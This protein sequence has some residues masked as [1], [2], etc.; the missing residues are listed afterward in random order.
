M[1][2]C[3]DITLELALHTYGIYM[4][5]LALDTNANLHHII[6]DFIMHIA[7]GIPNGLFLAL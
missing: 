3:V 2:K 5:I 4:S 1:I 6:A 7:N